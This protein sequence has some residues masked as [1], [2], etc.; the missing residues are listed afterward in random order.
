MRFSSWMPLRTWEKLLDFLREP[1]SMLSDVPLWLPRGVGVGPPPSRWTPSRP[2]SQG[3][4]RP[5]VRCPEGDCCWEERLSFARHVL[6]PCKAPCSLIALERPVLL[7]WSWLIWPLALSTC[8]I[9]GQF[10]GLVNQ[11]RERLIRPSGP[12]LQGASQG[13]PGLSEEKMQSVKTAASR[14][15][16]LPLPSA[17]AGGAPPP[18]RGPVQENWSHLLCQSFE[19]TFAELNRLW[20]KLGWP[21]R[22]PWTLSP[23]L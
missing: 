5:P 4:R 1:R 2:A 11:Q 17:P 13:W 19:E 23:C 21:V 7:S 16:L 22:S 20:G 10:Q 6:P 9:R 3:P 15:S 18:K 8:F 12:G 14:A